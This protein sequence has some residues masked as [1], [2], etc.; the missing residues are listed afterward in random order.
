MNSP[1]DEL[2]SLARV[3]RR[4]KK[5]PQFETVAEQQTELTQIHL[6]TENSVC[7][8]HVSFYSNSAN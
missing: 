7:D 3:L 4:V 8:D 6:G 5:I 2:I 1:D